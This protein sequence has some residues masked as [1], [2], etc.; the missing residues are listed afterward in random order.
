ME[1]ISNKKT[2]S[3]T[4]LRF[5]D[6]PENVYILSNTEQANSQMCKTVGWKGPLE[7]TVSSLPLRASKSL[8][9]WCLWLMKIIQ[10][11][12]SKKTW[13]G[14][15][16]VLVRLLLHITGWE[17]PLCVR[18]ARHHKPGHEVRFHQARLGEYTGCGAQTLA[19]VHTFVS[20][21]SKNYSGHFLRP[22]DHPRERSD[23]PHRFLP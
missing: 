17:Q 1:V 12:L 16:E 11:F 18:S 8:P 23:S 7:V 4:V 2:T 21:I 20:I 14:T 19:T 15:S 10:N 22:K 5:R 9:S 6:W 3:V 13:T